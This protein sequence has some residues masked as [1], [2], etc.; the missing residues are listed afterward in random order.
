MPATYVISRF[1]SF[2]ARICQF[3]SKLDGIRGSQ[4]ELLFESVCQSEGIIFGKL[5]QSEK[6]CV[7]Q[8][9][10]RLE[11]CFMRIERPLLAFL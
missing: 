8:F 9:H 1:M 2:H 5:Y 10:L 4:E 6:R 3:Q 11:L 7:Q